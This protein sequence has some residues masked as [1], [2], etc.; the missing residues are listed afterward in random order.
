MLDQLHSTMK[1]IPFFL[2]CTFLFLLT[3]CTS[4]ESTRSEGDRTSLPSIPP[5]KATIAEYELFFN[6][7]DYY[8]D[9]ENIST[10]KRSSGR[11][12]AASLNDS[13]I[14]QTDIAP[15]Y[16][17]QLFSSANIDE[18]N[19]MKTVAV[20][21]I[22]TDSVYIVYDPPI[23]KVRVGDFRSRVEANQ[24]L[25]VLIEKGFPD[26]WIVPDQINVRR[27]VR[28]KQQ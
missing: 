10:T 13:I 9:P 27:Q 12:R 14:L 19:T 6:N 4:T 5:A 23:Y 16:R 11:S 22:A 21:K 28:V 2:I 20:E 7:S 8:I 17:I 18:A 26:S 24:T 25:R 1:S 3:G 15:G